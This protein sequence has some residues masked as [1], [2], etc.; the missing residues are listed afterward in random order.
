V[1]DIA[2]S[3]FRVSSRRNHFVPKLNIGYQEQ[4]S[5][6]HWQIVCGGTRAYAVRFAPTISDDNWWEET[7]DSHF[8]MRRLTSAL[9]I[10]GAGL[11]HA[12]AMGRLIFNGMPDEIRWTSQFD[13]VGEVEDLDPTPVYDWF[14]AF[15]HHRVLGRAADDAHLALTYPSEA[16]VF[17]YRGLEWIVVTQHL[18]WSDIAKDIGVTPS[19][20]K[21]FKKFTNYE[22][23]IRHA[24]KSGIKLRASPE[25]YGTWVCALFDA[26]NAARARLEPGFTPMTSTQVAEAVFKS[27]PRIPY[28]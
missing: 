20:M 1:P 3:I 23:G 16:G 6:V 22:L 2:A 15:S 5:R 27:A 25:N 4:G 26:I 18:S 14:T 9:L 11:F 8:M 17:V 19:E 21:E 12:E 10:S 24:V 28:D 7:A 13:W